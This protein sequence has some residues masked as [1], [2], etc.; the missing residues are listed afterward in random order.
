MAVNE[1][2]REILDRGQPGGQP[3]TAAS[4]RALELSLQL[5][6]DRGRQDAHHAQVLAIAPLRGATLNSTGTELPFRRV[7]A[8]ARPASARLASVSMRISLMTGLSR[9]TSVQ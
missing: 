5:A 4:R 1:Q 7:R 8:R 9:N 3:P 2:G 6:H